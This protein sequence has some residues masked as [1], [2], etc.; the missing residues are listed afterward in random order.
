MSH[1][2]VSGV[3]RSVVGTVVTLLFGVVI[4]AIGVVFVVA[5]FPDG[6][7]DLRAYEAA[8]RCP[9]APS[10]PAE[11]RWTQEFT[12]SGVHLTNKRGDFDRVVLTGADGKTWEA[13]YTSRAPVVDSLDKGDRV[14]GTIW[15]G[16]LTEI[17]AD[18]ESQRTYDAPADLRARSL[19]LALITIPSGLLMAAVCLW[20]L[21]RRVADPT[22]GMAAALGLSI[23]LFFAGLF[24]P[25]LTAGSDKE[26][27]WPVAAVWL[28][29]AAVMTVVA[30]VYASRKRT[31]EAEPEPD[32]AAP[33]S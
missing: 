22:P 27:F 26:R 15:R 8:Q 1:L 30:C 32:A 6:V 17:A 24:A 13:R 19:V 33:A 29:I 4:A 16:R 14:T 11:C 2:S 23:A 9:A 3:L 12:V 7:R 18:G 31:A 21:A 25:V 28:P 10:G 20:R 5:E